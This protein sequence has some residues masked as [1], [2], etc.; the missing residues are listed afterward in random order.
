MDTFHNWQAWF[1]SFEKII[2]KKTHFMY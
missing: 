2:E 1:K